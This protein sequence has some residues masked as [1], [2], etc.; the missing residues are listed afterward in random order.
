MSERDSD[1]NDEQKTALQR[2]ATLQRM[3]EQARKGNRAAMLDSIEKLI[4]L[5]TRMLRESRDIDPEPA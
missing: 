3:R 4:D 2:L 1:F 5:E